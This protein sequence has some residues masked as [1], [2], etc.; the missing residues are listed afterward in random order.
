[1]SVEAESLDD[2]PLEMPQQEVGEIESSDLCFRERREDR[3]GREE[4]IAMRTGNALDTLFGEHRVEQSARTAIRI[5]HE[6]RAVL[7][8]RGADEGANRGGNALRS[9]VQ[10]R[11]QAAH[12]QLFPG[13]R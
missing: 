10:I 4:F 12:V 2:E 11:G 8:A 5:G 3:A 7:G 1:M 13:I 6:D 9:I